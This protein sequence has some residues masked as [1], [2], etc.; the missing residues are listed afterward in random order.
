MRTVGIRTDLLARIELG[1][2]AAY[3]EEACGFLIGSASEPNPGSRDILA[4]E[5]AENRFEG[6]R[7]RRYAI[8]PEE[9]RELERRLERTGREVVGF[10]HS[11]P[12]YPPE[13]SEFDREHA[14]PWYSY[15]V[16]SITAD[17]VGPTE[18][19]ELAPDRSKFERVKLEVRIPGADGRGGQTLSARRSP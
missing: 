7:R 13:P 1:G 19:F 11:H 2:R 10:Y 15:L 17:G 12:G 3:P 9:L 4:V 18:A 5:R 16:S 6:E 14:W 8:R